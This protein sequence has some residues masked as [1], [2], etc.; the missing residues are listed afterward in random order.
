[1]KRVVVGALA[2]GAL[3]ATGC[4]AA[5]SGAKTDASGASATGGTDGA[6]A[7]GKY[8]PC[9]VQ[10]IFKAPCQMCH[11]MPMKF[12]APM[13]LLTYD[14]T[15]RISSNPTKKVWELLKEYVSLG[16]MPPSSLPRLPEADKK[17]LLDWIAAGTPSSPAGASCP[18]ADGGAS[19]AAMPAAIGPDALPC[20]P[21]H[22]FVARGAADADPFSVPVVNNHYE[23][24][25]YQVPFTKDEQATAW[26][27]IIDNDKVI[28]HWIL[29][30]TEATTKPLNCHPSNRT[31]LMGWAPGGPN[32][33][34]PADVGLQL[35]DPGTW[36]LLEIHYNNSAMIQNAKDRSGVAI[37]TTPTKRPQEAGILAF[38]PRQIAIPA[39]ATDFKV[40]SS[41]PSELTRLLPGPLHVLGTGPHMHQLGTKFRTELTSGGVTRVMTD[42]ARWDFNTQTFYWL[43]PNDWIIKPGDQIT[44]TCTYTNPSNRIVRFGE[45]TEDEM[46]INF[47]MVYPIDFVP[48]RACVN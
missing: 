38:A 37:C 11:T 13:P 15:Q 7:S 25:P 8:L 42:V 14:D 48:T 31:F 5:D 28:H 43:N 6:V 16:F 44:T 36:L 20:K 2:F 39:G 10:R 23:C 29:Y 3:V 33:Q 30:G 41:C 18:G 1:M 9:D 26:A 21:N 12:G 35:P 47:A 45:R 22:T 32:S 46:C 17:T 27:P 34:M 40:V 4:G 19:D 24:F